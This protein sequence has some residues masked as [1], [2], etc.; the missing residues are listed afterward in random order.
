[1]NLF[2]NQRNYNYM[3]AIIRS[4]MTLEVGLVRLSLARV[5]SF[6]SLGD[7]VVEGKVVSSQVASL[8]VVVRSEIVV[9]D[10]NGRLGSL[11]QRISPPSPQRDT[12]VE[13]AEDGQSCGASSDNAEERDSPGVLMKVEK[14][15]LGHIVQ[16]NVRDTSKR[17]QLV[18]IEVG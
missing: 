12:P 2:I 16:S 14:E 7:N 6:V 8:K 9:D 15:G 5:V 18:R 3:A 13:K 4:Q 10:R 17:R 1:M 11:D